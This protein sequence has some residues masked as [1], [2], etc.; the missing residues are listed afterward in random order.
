MEAQEALS[1]CWCVTLRRRHAQESSKTYPRYFRHN[2]AES[3]R[4]NSFKRGKA[5]R[6]LGHRSLVVVVVVVAAVVVGVGVGVVGVVVVVVVVVEVVVAGVV[7]V[8][9]AGVVVVVVAVVV[10][11]AAA[12]VVV[13]SISGSSRCSH[14]WIARGCRRSSC[15]SSA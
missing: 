2:S 9:V 7:V 3:T 11:A 1:F 4:F 10:V 5:W 14:A 8:V 13:S 15:C 12:A 6:Q